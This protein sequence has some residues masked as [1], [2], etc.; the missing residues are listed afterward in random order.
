[1]SNCICRRS[2]PDITTLDITDHDKTFLLT[3]IHGLLE[4][5]HA[6][7][8]KLLIHCNLRLYGR[9]QI[10]Y[11]INDSLI[12]L[13]DCLCCS[14]QS[15]SILLKCFLRQMLRHIAKHRIKTYYNRCILFLNL[16]Y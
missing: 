10:I 11:R 13:P 1:M 8:T 16:L 2:R 15:L 5:D 3:V 4:G 6:R 9:N 14:F 7:N 12:V